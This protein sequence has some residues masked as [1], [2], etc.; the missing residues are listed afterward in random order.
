MVKDRPTTLMSTGD[1]ATR[2]D[3]TQYAKGTARALHAA[4][5]GEL[6]EIPDTRIETRWADYSRRAAEEGN[7]SSLSVPLPHR[8]RHGGAR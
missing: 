8:R 3:E 4:A 7:L 6:T 1:L 2:L 5:T